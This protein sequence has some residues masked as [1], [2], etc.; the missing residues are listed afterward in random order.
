MNEASVER[1]E[2]QVEDLGRVRYAEAFAAQRRLQDELIASRSDADASA[3]SAPGRVQRTA[4]IGRVLL[5]EHEPV[6]TITPRPG[7]R[8]HLLATPELLARHGV[9]VC[10][11]D[12][13]GDITY[14]GP[15]QLVAYPILDLNSI[16]LGLHEYMSMLESAVIDACAAF[17]VVGHRDPAARG[18]WVRNGDASGPA[19][20]VCAMGVRV[21]RWVS[22]HGLALNVDPRM[23]HFGLIVPCGLAG[24]PVTS[25]R[26]LLGTACPSMSD[27]KS[28]LSKQLR[29]HAG[30]AWERARG[31]TIPAR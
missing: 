23:E 4:S 10:E 20:K 9:E 30:L 31:R 5:V 15:G 24:R 16:N 26:A 21:R 7:V 12:R 17:G 13:G 2:L 25:L 27:V 1:F 14:H 18:V 8:E 19:A 3:G 11:T 6:V 29:A 22:M 28:E